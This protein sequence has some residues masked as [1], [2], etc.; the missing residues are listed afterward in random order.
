MATIAGLYVETH[1][2]ADGEAVILSAGLGG[3]GAYW[4]PQVEAL[5][6][7]YR[8]ILYDHRGTARSDRKLPP[9][10][11]VEQMAD[12][13]I[14]VLDGL[15]IASA[16]MVGHALGGHIGLALAL[17]APERLKSLVAVNGWARLEAHT[18]RCFET[19][20]SLLR[21][22]GKDAFIKATPLFLYPAAWMAARPKRLAEEE[23]HQRMAFPGV[24]T[25]EARIDAVRA[26]DIQDRLGEIKTPVL[27][28]AAEDDLL[29]PWTAA[30]ALAR[31]LPNGT[32][33]LMPRG[34]HAC[35]V[36][37]PEAF[38]PFLL[39]WL[40][41]E[42]LPHTPSPSSSG[43]TRGSGAGPA[44]GLQPRRRRATSPSETIMVEASELSKG[45]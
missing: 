2:P 28:L 3:S 17:K 15:G 41:G 23:K 33:A 31:G 38:N 43:L 25:T 13:V 35:N 29:S 16:H 9:G 40:A 8:V 4:L 6:R 24:E 14:A 12:D 37:E 36:T 39:A 45:K 22:S 27:S 18:A 5:A 26:F 32:F 42:P 44:G 1:G 34:G 20:L 7:R 11:S 21:D 19:R 10:H 30:E